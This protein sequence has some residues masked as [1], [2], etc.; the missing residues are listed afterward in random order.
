MVGG[1][2]GGMGGLN[3]RRISVIGYR[4]ASNKL[5]VDSLVFLACG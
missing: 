3:G 2:G 5:A 4:S 1:G